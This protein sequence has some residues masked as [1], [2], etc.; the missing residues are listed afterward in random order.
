MYLLPHLDNISQSSQYK[1]SSYA[2]YTSDKMLKIHKTHNIIDLPKNKNNRK[3]NSKKHKLESDDNQSDDIIETTLTYELVSSLNKDLKIHH[4]NNEYS[5][6]SDIKLN[7][8]HK[9]MV[10]TEV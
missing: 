2:Q 3:Y 5:D 6:N 10:D 4:G 7:F 9:H 1:L 8:S